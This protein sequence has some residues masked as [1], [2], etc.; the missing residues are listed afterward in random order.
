MN[1]LSHISLYVRIYDFDS[2]VNTITI[3]ET[4]LIFTNALSEVQMGVTFD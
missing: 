2:R 3:E 4:S 1:V